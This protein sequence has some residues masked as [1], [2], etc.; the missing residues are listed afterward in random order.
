VDDISRIQGIA[1][2]VLPR[3]E[4]KPEDLVKLLPRLLGK[5]KDELKDQKKPILKQLDVQFLIEWKVGIKVEDEDK[6]RFTSFESRLG[7]RILW[8]KHEVADKL[9]L[10]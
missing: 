8:K 2:A 7:C 6:E 1:I 4:G 10:D 5:Q 3:Y 9:L